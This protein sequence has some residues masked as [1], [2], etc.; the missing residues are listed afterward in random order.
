MRYLIIVFLLFC[1]SGFSQERESFNI[2]DGVIAFQTFGEGFPV[3]IINGGPGMNS[4][5]FESLAK[6]L[7]D[8]NRTIIYDQRGTGESFLKD[9]NASNMTMDHM[10]EDIES[11]RDHLGYDNWIV[12]GQ[13][14]G[15]MLAYAYAAKYP[16]RVK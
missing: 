4:R 3:L 12:F 8:N 7:S 16:E 5:G 2:K 10:V 15:G 14:F 13:S 1:S 6:I 9:M 11:L